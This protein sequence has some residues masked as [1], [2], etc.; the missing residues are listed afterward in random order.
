MPQQQKKKKKKKMNV[1]KFKPTLK[2]YIL[3][4]TLQKKSKD[5]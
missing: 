4:F 1:Y 2:V 3:P 5:K